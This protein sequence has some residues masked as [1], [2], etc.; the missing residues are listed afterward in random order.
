M[1]VPRVPSAH[2]S[3]LLL[4]PTLAALLGAWSVTA[5]AEESP[6][7]QPK[8]TVAPAA[9]TDDGITVIGDRDRDGY[10][11]DQGSSVLRTPQ[12][13]KETPQSVQV[14]PKELLRANGVT[15]LQDAMRSVPGAALGSGEG[16]SPGDR[17][18]LRGF[19]AS[20]DIYVDGMHDP[21]NYLRDTFNANS[22][23][24]LKGPSSVLFGRGTPGGAINTVTNKPTDTWTGD[25]TL[26]LGSYSNKRATVGVGGPLADKGLLD[27]RLDA[28][29]Q[30]TKSFRDEVYYKRW[31]VAPS[32][33]TRVGNF[34]VLLQY[35]HQQENSMYDPGVATYRG[36]PTDVDINKFYGFE[37]DDY[38]KYNVSF[39]TGAIGYRFNEN[40]TVRNQTRYSTYE[41]DLRITTISNPTTPAQQLLIPRSQTLRFDKLN[42]IDNLTEGQYLG[43]IAGRPFSALGGVEFVREVNDNM[44]KNSTGVP[45]ISVFNPDS[46]PS[47]VG[48][49]RANDFSGTL[50]TNNLATATTSG[51][52]GFVTYE[53]IDHLTAVAGVRFD[54]FKAEVDDRLPANADLERTDRYVTTHEGLVYAIIPE[55]SLY[56]SYATAVNPSAQTLTLNASTANLDPERTRAIEAGIKGETRD[57]DLGASLALF[58]TD[59]FNQVTGTAPNQTVD[60]QTRVSGVEI[61]TTGKP[62]ERVSLSG[63]VVFMKGEVLKSA[64]V[65]TS[66]E[67]LTPNIPVEGKEPLGTPRI[68]GSLWLNVDLGHGLSTG[69]GVYAVGQRYGD[70]V[71]TQIIPGYARLDLSAAYHHDFGGYDGFLQLNVFNVGNTT[72]YDGDRNRFITPGAPI[73]G[74]VTAGVTF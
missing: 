63:G 21:A 61:N 33:S 8:P 28:M 12:P 32:V 73:N 5:A 54:S 15:S 23:E 68:S 10:K 1:S 25:G 53:V 65:G 69:A 24:V 47:T 74:Q 39:Y 57:K 4:V 51:I 26:T 22:I 46:S 43:K 2:R 58:R 29:V 60:G 16:S 11:V 7:T 48:A 40:W 6:A 36:R 50:A 14:I 56:G 27:M 35:Y 45:A 3:S 49:G 71:N 41:R 17:I 44:G 30:D 38:Q 37:D 34:D 18:Y 66:S 13:L 42:G 67:D 72:Y 52:Y 64:N 70:A 31:G 9:T 20:N 55:I 19:L 62:I 59:K